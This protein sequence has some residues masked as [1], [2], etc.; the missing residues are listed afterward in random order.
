VIAFRIIRYQLLHPIPQAALRPHHR[1]SVHHPELAWDKCYTTSHK[2]YRQHDRSSQ[3][4]FA[5]AVV[6]SSPA[7]INFD[8]L[9]ILTKCVAIARI[10]H[11]VWQRCGADEGGYKTRDTL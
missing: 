9:Q 2:N 6:A 7:T 10:S 4:P 3:I 5:V 8:W 11:R 1:Y